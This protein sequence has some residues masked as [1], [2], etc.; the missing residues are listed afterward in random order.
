MKKPA[1]AGFLHLPVGFLLAVTLRC[2]LRNTMPCPSMISTLS[3]GQTICTFLIDP[4]NLA[5]KLSILP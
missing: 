2:D 3:S 5:M 4:L 1:F